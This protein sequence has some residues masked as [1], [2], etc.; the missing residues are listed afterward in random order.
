MKITYVENES[1]PMLWCKVGSEVAD[2][3]RPFAG[4]TFVKSVDWLGFLKEHLPDFNIL[5]AFRAVSYERLPFILENGIDVDPTD[6][7]F[8]C[9][10]LDM[11]KAWE[12]GEW[13]KVVLVLNLE[14]LEHSYKLVPKS[15]P[16]SELSDLMQT[17]PS[18]VA[19]EFEEK[20]WLSRLSENDTRIGTPYEYEWGY[21]IAEDPFDALQAIL[22]FS[23]NPYQAP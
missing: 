9:S 3:K 17:Y 7:V 14:K 2:Q 13:P 19:S 6:S 22:V 16:K 10:M 8:F 21:W 1:V 18:S 15:T 23:D 4:T 20:I 11:S 12:Y 5:C